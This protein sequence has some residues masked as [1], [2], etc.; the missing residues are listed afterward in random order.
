[1]VLSVVVRWGPVMTAVTGTLVARPVRVT[2]IQWC[3][4]L[5]LERRVR[6]VLGG[7]RIVGKPRTRRGSIFRSRPV[8]DASGAPVLRDQGPTGRPGTARPIL[9]LT[10]CMPCSFGLLPHP[11]S[12]PRS[13]PNDPL[14]LTVTVRWIPLVPAA[15]GT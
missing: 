12:E 15:Y 6:P 8:A 14:E 2:C 3:Y 4:W 1:V 7:H 13:L 10:P 5:H 11:R 9:A